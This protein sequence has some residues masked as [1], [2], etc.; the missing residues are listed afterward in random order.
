[1]LLAQRDHRAEIFLRHENLGGDDRLADFLH[2][3]DFRQLG[4]IFHLDS[5]A[6]AHQHLIHHRRRG[7]DQVLVEL[8]LQP[9][10]HDFHV[11]QAEEA[12]AEAE[13][14]RLRHFRLVVQ[15]GIV[16]LELL[17]RVAQG[18]VLVGF[19]RIEAGEDLRLDFLEA[20]Q[21]LGGTPV[22]RGHRVAHLG[23]IE[24][25]DAG[26]D[27]AD[28]AGAQ[29]AAG[30]R[31]RREHAD[32]FAQVLRA[33]RHQQ[34]LVLGAHRA[35]HHAHQHHHAD[36]VVEPGVD[37]QRLQRRR[38]IAL[39]RRDAGDDR[40]EDVIDAEAGLGRTQNRLGGVDAD[41][42]LD[43]LARVVRV[44]RRQVDLVQ[45]RHHVDAQFDRRVAVGHGLRLDALRGIDHQQRAF[46]G[47]QGTADLVGEIDVP[48]RV[49][50]V[51]VVGPAVARLVTERRRLRLDGDA[52]LALDIHRIEHLRLHFAVGQAAAAMDDAI[53]Q[54]GFAVVDVGNDGE[55]A[56]VIHG[57]NK[58]GAHSSC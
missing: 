18:I 49:D 7:G 53:G 34:D 57:G 55:V 39:G 46:A 56:D 14:Q 45:H 21:R 51:Q 50:Q 20:G 26:D 12:A 16:E 38:R 23:G 47:G 4:R 8:A 35:I 27:E 25:L 54:G 15:R 32:L 29:F 42:V 58:K 9:F 17:Q 19:D 52:T 37:D 24:F 11:Q 40:F 3:L 13:A 48:R 44:G 22:G 31:L 30:H 1:M 6:V 41:D 10:L 36:I 43:F 28:L 33:F 5:A 2:L